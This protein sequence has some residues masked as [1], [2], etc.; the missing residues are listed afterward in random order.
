M[1]SS[2]AKIGPLPIGVAGTFSTGGRPLLIILNGT[3]TADAPTYIDAE[4]EICAGPVK[5]C[6]FQNATQVVIASV[7]NGSTGSSSTLYADQVVT[8]PKGT[9]TL[10]IDAIQHTVT[11]QKDV[12]HW[13]IL[14]L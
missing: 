3:A 14:A 9:Y 13:T 6:N 7:P 11:T 1:L 5:P 4:L 8:L 2:D 12:F 10:G